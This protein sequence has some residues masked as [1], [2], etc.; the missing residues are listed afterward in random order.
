MWTKV[1]VTTSLDLGISI[2]LPQLNLALKM[3]KNHIY[4]TTISNPKI[5]KT[6]FWGKCG[7][8]LSEIHIHK[9]AVYNII[10]FS[11][12]LC[13]GT[14]VKVKLS[15]RVPSRLVQLYT[16][17]PWHAGSSCDA[18]P[19]SSSCDTSELQSPRR[20][21]WVGR[22]R[23]TWTPPAQRYSGMFWPGESTTTCTNNFNIMFANTSMSITKNSFNKFRSCINE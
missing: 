3:K 21:A 18:E 8:I 20:N 17:T 6:S 16:C 13:L 1:K 5:L 22:R 10:I 12:S 23:K 19:P 14:S 11:P 4:C 7:K 9:L 15:C 2:K